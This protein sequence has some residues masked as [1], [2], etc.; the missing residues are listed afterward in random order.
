MRDRWLQRI[1][2]IVERRERVPPESDDDS[3]VGDRQDG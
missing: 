2:A 1:E 3:F